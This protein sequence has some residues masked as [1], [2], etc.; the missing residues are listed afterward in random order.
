MR[1]TRDII[2]MPTTTCPSFRTCPIPT[3][4]Q[5]YQN[6]Y[7]ICTPTLTSLKHLSKKRRREEGRLPHEK[8]AEDA[9]DDEVTTAD[10]RILSAFKRAIERESGNANVKKYENLLHALE[11]QKIRE[12]SSTMIEASE[13]MMGML[14]D[15]KEK[16]T[17]EEYINLTNACKSIHHGDAAITIGRAE[18]GRERTI[19]RSNLQTM[20]DFVDNLNSARAI[21]GDILKK[22]RR[23]EDLRNDPQS[24]VSLL[25]K[26]VEVLKSKHTSLISQAHCYL[27]MARCDN[28]HDSLLELVNYVSLNLSYLFTLYESK[29]ILKKRKTIHLDK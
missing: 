27:L 21:H 5:P 28:D 10:M 13:K 24:D 9:E 12:Q 2:H 26:E 23:L 29:N 19:H 25:K 15:V 20:Q 7:D 11:G 18:D 17:N 14:F 16:L 6:H 4:E 1:V 8:D 3:S 22:N